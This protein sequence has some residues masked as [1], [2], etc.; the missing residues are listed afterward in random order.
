M[1]RSRQGAIAAVVAAGLLM[2]FSLGNAASASSQVRTDDPD[3][4]EA[5]AQVQ[6]E[7]DAN[8]QLQLELQAALENTNRAIVEA[9]R[10]LRDLETRLPVAEAELATAEADLQVVIQHQREVEERLA[11][12]EAEDA[13]VAKQIEADNAKLADLRAI[14]AELARAA[15]RGENSDATLRLVLGA[16]TSEDFVDE[17]TAQQTLSRTQGNAL[18][19][20]EQISAMNRNRGARQEAVREY[21]A[22]L[23]VLA[24]QYVDEAEAARTL[25]EE[26]KKEIEDLLV[27]QAQLKRYLEEQKDEYLRQQD[28]LEEQAEQ[29]KRDL[30]AIILESRGLGI[31][32]FDGTWGYPVNNPVVVSP[33][34]MRFHPIYHVWRMHNGT[35]FRAWCG[36]PIYA[37]ADGFVEWTR[38]RGGYGNQVLLNHGEYEGTSYMSSYNHLASFA[39]APE[40]YVVRGDVIGYS[41]TTGDSTGCHLHFEIY[42][43]GSPVNPMSYM[44]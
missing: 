28:E 44:P 24:D 23:K 34:G 17:F 18:A 7:R 42:V 14:V 38:Y 22:A 3:Y 11:A 35:D 37:A 4:A 39:V 9:D 25:A 36:V 20:M 13:R 6:A 12:A 40:D 41:G 33:F 15:Y 29:L 26:K 21:I 5:L 2:G 30:I 19:E 1:T 32:Y 43:N 16:Q 8:E 31:S 27:E 10:R